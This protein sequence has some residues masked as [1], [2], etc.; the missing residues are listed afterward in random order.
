MKSENFTSL[1]AQMRKEMLNLVQML[2]RFQSYNETFIKSAIRRFKI[3]EM[4]IKYQISR[5][6]FQA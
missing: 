1:L 3:L 4:Q 6:T 2:P 5:K